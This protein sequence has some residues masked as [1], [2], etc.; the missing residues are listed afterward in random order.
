MIPESHRS[1]IGNRMKIE[2]D[3]DLFEKLTEL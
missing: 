3:R 1:V 2:E